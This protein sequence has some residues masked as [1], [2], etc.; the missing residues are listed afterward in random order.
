MSTYEDKNDIAFN[1][2]SL[3]S[4]ELGRRL[5]CQRVDER[6]EDSSAL[7]IERAEHPHCRRHVDLAVDAFSPWIH[8]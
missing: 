4:I 8:V 1:L 6:E 3:S 7:P 5:V 2:E